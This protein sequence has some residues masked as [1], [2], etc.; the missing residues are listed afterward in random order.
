MV[1][2]RRI[3][4]P[5]DFS[6]VSRR[7]LD[8][9]TDLARLHM[10]EITCLHAAPPVTFGW[11]PDDSGLGLASPDVTS[12]LEAQLVSFVQPA[13]RHGV[14]ANAVVIPGDPASS[15]IA[16][17]NTLPADLL[18]MGMR[19]RAGV[20]R[21]LLGSV[22]ERVL[23]RVDCPVLTVPGGDVSTPASPPDAFRRILCAVDFSRASLAAVRYA[24]SL[25]ALTPGSSLALIHVDVLVDRPGLHGPVRDALLRSHG[26]VMWNLL[27]LLSEAVPE[28]IPNWVR[29]EAAVVSGAA[30]SEV[31]K[32]AR[33][34][35]ADLIVVGK[36]VR[37]RL[38]GL[39]H[40]SPLRPLLRK[41]PCPALAVGAQAEVAEA[42][43]DEDP[44]GAG[45]RP[46]GGPVSPS[47]GRG[48]A[49]RLPL[50]CVISRRRGASHVCLAARCPA[51]RA[52]PRAGT[53]PGHPAA[54]RPR[55]RTTGARQRDA[56]R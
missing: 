8:Y 29:T 52:T 42:G 15:I 38:H 53:L 1:K 19:R 39:L 22:A 2:V 10:A 31:L 11:L 27:R 18:V 25:A 35:Q 9:A 5:V 56:R 16:C 13:L 48:G 30:S 55:R 37:G 47:R 36:T 34:R 4:C 24:A 32:A 51:T 21:L 6:A 14:A 43:Q 50:R 45:R 54:R 3:L 20:E 28:G 33:E 12:E 46:A 26:Y 17:A 44:Q 40:S 7:A 23:Q 41:A 49:G